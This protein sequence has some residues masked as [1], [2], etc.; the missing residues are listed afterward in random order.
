MYTHQLTTSRRPLLGARM[1]RRAGDYDSETL[2]VLRAFL[3]DLAWA[4]QGE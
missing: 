4:D 3:A 1:V 2:E